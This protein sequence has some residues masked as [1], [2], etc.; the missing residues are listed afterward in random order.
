[1]TYDQNELIAL[2][3]Q[4]FEKIARE[5]PTG[6]GKVRLVGKKAFDE[7]GELVWRLNLSIPS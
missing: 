4:T 2:P 6:K 1:M 7:R 5:S 3:S